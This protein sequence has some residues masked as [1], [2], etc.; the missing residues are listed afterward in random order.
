MLV[1]LPASVA[2]DQ[3]QSGFGEES[4]LPAGI[5]RVLGL[6]SCACI[7]AAVGVSLEKP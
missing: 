4:P 5:P 2:P 6:L 7:L 3:K 1:F